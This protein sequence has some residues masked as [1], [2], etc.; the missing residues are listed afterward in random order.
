MSSIFSDSETITISTLPIEYYIVLHY[1]KHFNLQFSDNYHY[2]TILLRFFIL[3]ILN[4]KVIKQHYN[5][6]Y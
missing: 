4:R 3:I 6:I 2:L 1:L 5:I